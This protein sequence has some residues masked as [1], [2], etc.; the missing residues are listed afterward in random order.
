MGEVVDVGT[1]KVVIHKAIDLGGGQVWFEDLQ[2]SSRWHRDRLDLGLISTLRAPVNPTI[3]PADQ[4][5]LVWGQGLK[6]Y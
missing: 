1:R 3:P 5:F 6:T 4:S 2:S